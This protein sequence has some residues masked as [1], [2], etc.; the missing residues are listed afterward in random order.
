MLV[1]D[2]GTV[3]E[4]VTTFH[5]AYGAVVATHDCSAQNQPPHPS[6]EPGA[7]FRKTL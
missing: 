4:M 6:P 1:T 3:H 7:R 5:D 2:P